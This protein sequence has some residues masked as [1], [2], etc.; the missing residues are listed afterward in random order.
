[1][2]KRRRMKRRAVSKEEWKYYGKS[3]IRYTLLSLLIVTIWQSY[4]RIVVD[5]FDVYLLPIFTSFEANI[6]GAIFIGAALLFALY[7]LYYRFI[8]QRHVYNPYLVIVVFWCTVITLYYRINGEYRYVSLIGSLSYVDVLIGV[9]SLYIVLAFVNY[10]RILIANIRAK[11][12][13][14]Q[15]TTLLLDRHVSSLAEDELDWKD[16]IKSFKELLKGLPKSHSLSIAVNAQWGGGKT[17]FLHM[18]WSTIDSSEY[19]VV[20]FNPRESKTIQ[21]IQEDFFQQIMSVL[22]KYDGRAEYNLRKYMAA[23]QIIDDRSWLAKLLNVYVVLNKETYREKISKICKTLPIRILVIIDDFDRLMPDEI[24]EVLKLIGSNASFSNFIFLT[25]YDRSKVNSVLGQAD[26]QDGSYFTDKYFDL[27]YDLPMRPY[28]YIRDYFITQLSRILQLDEGNKNAIK[29]LMVENE[30]MFKSLLPT[31]RDVKR[32]INL[33]SV[34]YPLVREEVFF[35]EYFYVHLIKYKYPEEYKDLS[36]KKYLESNVLRN[37]D[38]LFLKKEVAESKKIKCLPILKH[39]F[40]CEGVYNE[41]LYRHIY[42]EKS[43]E[44]YFINKLYGSLT[45]H[46]MR[47]I[48][49]VDYAGM[50]ALIDEWLKDEQQAKDFSNYMQFLR[51]DGFDSKDMFMKYATAAAYMATKSQG[52]HGSIILGR[53]LYAENLE[54]CVKKYA[55]DIEGYKKELLEILSDTSIDP[56]LSDLRMRHYLYKN[57]AKQEPLYILGDTDIWPIIKNRFMELCGKQENIA[58]TELYAYLQQCVDGLDKASKIILDKECCEAYRKHVEN[59]PDH[60]VRSFVRQV[61][62][63]SD[64]E[65][66]MIGCEPFWEQIF[67][68]IENLKEFAQR[69]KEQGVDSGLRMCNFI[70]LFEAHGYQPIEFQHN[71]VVQEKI[72]GDL[73]KEAEMLHV[74]QLIEKKLNNALKRIKKTESL[75]KRA[76][77]FK[78]IVEENF[79]PVNFRADLLSRINDIL[80]E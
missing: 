29:R 20:Y 34:D 77:E 7:V 10:A 64:P 11:A 71:G 44:N 67:G 74:L 21:E 40:V 16:E 75:K 18:L 45:I 42:Q 78:K 12:K 17:S 36:L 60:Y 41:P 1:M 47:K 43:F 48:F 22:S 54:R 51:M 30:E 4:E 13:T 73:K 49:D 35:Y 32:L 53:L 50:R 55:L 57:K 6:W 5:L 62:E 31:I 59:S 46:E 63:S 56:L 27:E 2:H 26:N 15:Q 70:E 80:H 14:P 52:N 23:L 28:A 58:E 68:N 38:G 69:C 19:E 3:L 61:M 66:N 39:L 8:K 65:W 37:F 9:G 33:M 76:E 24:I 25:A 72:D 79:L